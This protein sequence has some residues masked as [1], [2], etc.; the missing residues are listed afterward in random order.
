MGLMD[1]KRREKPLAVLTV[2]ILG[3]VFLFT[4]IIDPQLKK[5]RA[6][7]SRLAQLQLD[8]TK[9]RGNLLI[10]DRIEKAY[11]QIS[12]LIAVQNSQQQQI[13]EFT[14]LLDQIY[15]KLNVRIRSVKILPAADENYY[16]KLSIR[17][18]MTGFVKDFLNFIDA[19]E[20]CPA[21]IKIELFDL[22]TQELQDTVMASM[23]ISRIV[24]AEDR[25]AGK[26]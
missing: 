9:A 14:H 17:I 25:P 19:V 16:Q 18:E 13:S 23:I 5:H 2:V 3:A 15:S 6:L 22:T 20:Q 12:P 10:K 24:S 8:L 7:S 11:T 21:P 1:S 4:S 26:K